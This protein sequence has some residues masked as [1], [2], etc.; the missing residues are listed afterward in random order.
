MIFDTVAIPKRSDF[1]N[2]S[3]RRIARLFVLAFAGKRGGKS[4]WKCICDCGNVT[5]VR[6]NHL[7]DGGTKSCGCLTLEKVTTHGHARAGSQTPEYR[8]WQD[9]KKRCENPNSK[10]SKNYSERG[11]SVC[12]RWSKYEN[13]IEDM[14][15]KPSSEYT[16]E[17]KDNDS[18][19]SPENCVWATRQEQ[20]KNKRTNVTITIDGA[21]KCLSDWAKESC[22]TRETIHAR[23]KK[24]WSYE[25]AIMTPAGKT[26]LSE[27]G[28]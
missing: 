26:K 18:G 19:Y 13:F 11:I 16:L 17:R 3:G 15:V 9:M 22:V 21:T 2:L 1:I 8:S 12:E 5:V 25:D 27:K 20:N 14:G 23:V 10:D 4:Y 6:S 24:G 7:A 28:Q